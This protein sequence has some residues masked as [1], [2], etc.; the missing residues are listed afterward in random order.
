[1]QDHR[2]EARHRRAR[3]R[4]AALGEA[5]T[6][7]AARGHALDHRDQVGHVRRGE[8]VGIAARAVRAVG[9]T[10]LHAHAGEPALRERMEGGVVDVGRH[11][12]E[13]IGREI[14]Q[15]RTGG[16]AGARTYAALD[17]APH[18]C[19]EHG[20]ARR[21]GGGLTRREVH[22]GAGGALVGRAVRA[23]Q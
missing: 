22:L 17:G 7:D 5:V 21:G 20:D 12:G 4:V 11:K 14:D 2:R 9:A 19:V 6:R 3:L 1:M 16:H 13:R 15:R 18:A 8:V 10:R 23:K